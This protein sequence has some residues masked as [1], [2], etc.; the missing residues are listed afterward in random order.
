MIRGENSQFQHNKASNTKLEMK[1]LRSDH[2]HHS[3]NCFL[4]LTYKHERLDNYKVREA[5]VDVIS[6]QSC[7]EALWRP[8]YH[9]ENV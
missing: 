7:T 4:S 9:V 6:S 5:M 3:V 2:I 1:I 8:Q